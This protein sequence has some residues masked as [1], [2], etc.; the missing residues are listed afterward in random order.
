[1][2][3]T[4]QINHNAASRLKRSDKMH[5]VFNSGKS[6]EGSISSVISRKDFEKDSRSYLQH[7]KTLAIYEGETKVLIIYSS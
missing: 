7:S 1:M 6:L 3:K 4:M 5:I 2:V